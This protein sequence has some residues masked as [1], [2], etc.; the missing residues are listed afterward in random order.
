MRSCSTQALHPLSHSCPK[1]SSEM[2]PI[3]GKMCINLAAAGRTSSAGMFGED[4]W[5]DCICLLS[6]QV[7]V[8]GWMEGCM[9]V[10]SAWM[11]K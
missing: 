1:E 6:A 7:M 9:L 5:V 10:M 4:M 11:V 2:L 3:C 8:S